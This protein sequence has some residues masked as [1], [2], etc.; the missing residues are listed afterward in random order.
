MVIHASQNTLE[1]SI[2]DS[3]IFFKK[4]T[5]YSSIYFAYTK[6]MCKCA[7][8]FNNATG[9]K[10]FEVQLLTESFWSTVF[11]IAFQKNVA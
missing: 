5:S 1:D 11:L 8:F 3:M 9:V 6:A 2:I 7:L 10:Q 4:I